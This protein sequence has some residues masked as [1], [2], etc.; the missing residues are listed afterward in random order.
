MLYTIDKV[1]DYENFQCSIQSF[2][3]QQYTLFD[4]KIFDIFNIF[5]QNMVFVYTLEPPRP[6]KAGFLRK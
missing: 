2:V 6:M 5:A 3:F 1:K 4:W